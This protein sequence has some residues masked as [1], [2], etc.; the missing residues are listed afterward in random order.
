MITQCPECKVDHKGL[1][2]YEHFAFAAGSSICPS[3]G[4]FVEL[5]QPLDILES[6]TGVTTPLPNFDEDIFEAGGVKEKDLD[7]HEGEKRPDHL[8]SPKATSP[9][10]LRTRTPPFQLSVNKV[11]QNCDASSVCLE[12]KLTNLTTNEVRGHLWL[13]NEDGTDGRNRPFSL[14][15]AISGSRGDHHSETIYPQINIDRRSSGLVAVRVQ[16]VDCGEAFW[17]GDLLLRWEKN[18][19]VSVGL[20]IDKS[21][22]AENYLEGIRNGMTGD[23]FNINTGPTLA[24]DHWQNVSVRL[25]GPKEL[26]HPADVR[27]PMS[28]AYQR[29]RYAREGYDATPVVSAARLS[30]SSTLPC[31]SE[32]I[33]QLIAGPTLHLG[34][35]RT[36]DSRD[37]LDKIP[38]DIALRTLA[39]D[40][41]DD[42]ISRY[43]GVIRMNRG[44]IIY[45]NLSSL[46]SEV[47]GRHLKASETIRLRNNALIC[48][49]RPALTTSPRRDQSLGLQVRRTTCNVQTELYNLLVHDAHL[50][51]GFDVDQCYDVITLHRTDQVR[52]L[53]HY[54]F[55]SHATMVGKNE[56][57]CGWRIDHASVQ[58]VHAILLWFDG[59]FWI[60]PSSAN[61]SVTVDGQVIQK[62]HVRRLTAGSTLEIG[63]CLYTVLPEWKQHIID[64]R[65]CQGHG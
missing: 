60:E 9:K 35:A 64:C 44:D 48:P 2:G 39:V 65:C 14:Q 51:S 45:E 62:N 29:P 43:H 40:E 1:P 11:P 19:S 27:R 8:S 38:N 42:Y 57:I 23:V 30:L 5:Q 26:M 13:C 31:G 47:A 41:Y 21:I 24:A 50:G 10:P 56:S 16:P 18:G 22:R 4:C 63:E 25:R 54:I 61:C 6:A 33:V 28:Q 37:H 32:S 49:G 12:V 46:G 15:P 3:C 20:N 52:E 53:E 36:W 55:F 59:S 7:V 58:A 34:R 17:Q